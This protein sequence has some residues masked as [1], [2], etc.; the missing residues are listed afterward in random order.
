MSRRRRCLLTALALVA[1]SLSV[2][3][4][5]GTAAA[6]PV[7]VSGTL[8][9]T[10]GSPF[11][12]GHVWVFDADRNEVAQE[13]ITQAGAYT[14]QVEPGTYRFEFFGSLDEDETKYVSFAMTDVEVTGPMTLNASTPE[15]PVT[16]HV[17]DPDGAPVSAPV[18][19]RCADYD[20][21]TELLGT[22][23][24]SWSN[25]PTATVYGFPAEFEDRFDT[26]RDD[27]CWLVVHP[28]GQAAIL[29]HLFSDPDFPPR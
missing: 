25:G 28:A 23:V 13:G 7:T 29:T 21:D 4:P 24:S 27:G 12:H 3:L 5:A 22:D 16:V 20:N 9:T 14:L 6:D 2:V 17:E 10:L 15:S 11:N 1:A 26:N 8:T 18:N 19:L